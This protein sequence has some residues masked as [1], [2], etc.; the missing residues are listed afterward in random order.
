M[1]DDAIRSPTMINN[2]R[3]LTKGYLTDRAAEFEKRF[4][5]DK[6]QAAAYIKDTCDAIFN[7]ARKVGILTEMDAAWYFGNEGQGGIFSSEQEAVT[8]ARVDGE[9]IQ[10][11]VMRRF[12]NLVSNIG[13]SF[14]YRMSGE[15]QEVALLILKEHTDKVRKAVK[16]G[17]RPRR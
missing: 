13:H 14:R 11:E 10:D 12:E 15:M 16:D 2:L 4:I 3:V 8:R 6:Y 9:L 5:E 17:E 1:I 7:F